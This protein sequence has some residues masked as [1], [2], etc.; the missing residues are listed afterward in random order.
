MIATLFFEP[1]TRTRLSFETAVKR[2]GGEVLSVNDSAQSSIAKGESLQDTI[3][4]VGNY[5]DAIVLRHPNAGAAQAASIVSEVPIINA[6]DGAGDH[7]SQALLD[8][9]TILQQKNRVDDLNIG[10]IGDVAHSRTLQNFAK[11][12]SA[13]RPNLFLITPLGIQAPMEL[14]RFLDQRRTKFRILHDWQAVLSSLDVVYIN[15]IQKERYANVRDFSKITNFT[16]TTTTMTQLK[17]DA[18]VMSPLPRV[19]EIHPDVDNDNR[20]IYFQQAN[21][22]TFIRM[23]LLAELCQS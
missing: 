2:L 11:L 4:S 3:R 5:A 15:R 9:Y 19:E 6:G 14:T 12:T 18:I 1:S 7:P 13:Y 17:P 8:V 22:G 20:A 10:V 23:A 21:N 16:V